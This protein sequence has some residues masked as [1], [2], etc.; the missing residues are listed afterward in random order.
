MTCNN[1]HTHNDNHQLSFKEKLAK[2]LKHWS[3]HNKEHNESYK[4]WSA[5]AKER[6]YTD[7]SALIEEAAAISLKINKYFEKAEDLIK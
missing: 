2:I 7:I 5:E 3:A 6:G 4:K 1:C